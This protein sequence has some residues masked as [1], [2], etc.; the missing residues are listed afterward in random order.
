ML[1]RVLRAIDREWI[2]VGWVGMQTLRHRMIAL[3]PLLIVTPA[4][5]L[6]EH[7]AYDAGAVIVVVGVVAASIATLYIEH[8]RMIAVSAPHRSARLFQRRARN[9]LDP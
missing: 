3:S 1:R 8:R 6:I 4:A 5:M 7:W 2:R 9:R